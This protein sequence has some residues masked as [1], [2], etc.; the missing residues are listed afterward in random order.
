MMKFGFISIFF[1]C[2]FYSKTNAKTVYV[3][4][5]GKKYHAKNCQLAKTG[6]RGI[7]LT[8]AIKQGYESCK[9]C[10]VSKLVV[11][12]SKEKVNLERKNKKYVQL[13]HDIITWLI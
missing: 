3:S 6:K 5:S 12:T 2:L 9:N 10:K 13:H 4:E 7:T 8:E 11:V 1:I